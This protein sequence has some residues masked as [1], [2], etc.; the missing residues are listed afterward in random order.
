M[1]KQSAEIWFPAKRY[2]I[3]WG[4]PIHWKGWVVLGVYIFLFI[5]LHFFVNPVFESVLWGS[6]FILLI[7]SFIVIC[8]IKGEKLSWRWSRKE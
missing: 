3:G 2:G 8:W 5:L 4:A 7:L 1:K 6:C